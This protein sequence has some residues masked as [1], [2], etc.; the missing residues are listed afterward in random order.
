M[1]S[2]NSKY[3]LGYNIGVA[4]VSLSL[5]WIGL[6]KFTIAEAEAIKPLIENHF[7]MSWLYNVLSVQG[8]SILIGVTEIIIGI[9]LILSFWHPKI[10]KYL[11]IGSTVIFISTLSFLFTTPGLF[12]SIE[13]FP[14]TDFFILKDITLLGISI[15]VWGHSEAILKKEQ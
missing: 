10:G 15:M 1:K 9:G 6:F 13:G 7:A 11:G 2:G 12:R 3:N 14:I 8:V 4:G 5:I